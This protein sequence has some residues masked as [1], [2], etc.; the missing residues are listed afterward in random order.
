MSSRISTLLMR[1]RQLKAEKLSA[2]EALCGCPSYSLKVMSNHSLGWTNFKCNPELGGWHSENPNHVQHTCGGCE[3]VC[4]RSI[5]QPFRKRLCDFAFLNSASCSGAP[6]D[7][8]AVFL[9]GVT[10]FQDSLF[11]FAEVS[12]FSLQTSLRWRVN[13]D[14]K[15]LKHPCYSW[16]SSHSGKI[17]NTFY[18]EQHHMDIRF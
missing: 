13:W 8:E 4:P 16:V 15:H 11:A 7:A 14:Q 18:Q 3:C 17:V 6:C 1:I 9:T 5:T 2:L 12:L 10:G